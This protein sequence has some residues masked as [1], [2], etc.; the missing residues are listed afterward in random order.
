MAEFG[1]QYESIPFL[2]AIKRMVFGDLEIDIIARTVK[3]N[4]EILK[5]TSTE[6]ICSRY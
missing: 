2:M 3:K 6:L 5:L 4:N 1:L